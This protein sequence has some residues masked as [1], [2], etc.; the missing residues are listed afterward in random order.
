LGGWR[1]TARRT[2]ELAADALEVALAHD[3]SAYD[4][5]YVA[6]SRRLG[7]PL[8]TAGESLVRALAQ[9]SFDVR[10]LGTCL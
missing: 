5:A 1:C 4:A 8:I 10:C 3:V 6:L 9:T 2:A 7:L